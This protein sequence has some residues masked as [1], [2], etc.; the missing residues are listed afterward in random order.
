MQTVAIMHKASA[1]NSFTELADETPKLEDSH[2][3]SA[4]P[5][6]IAAGGEVLSV[7]NAKPDISDMA[8]NVS[9]FMSNAPA[10]VQYKMFRQINQ[11]NNAI[12]EC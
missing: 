1:S 11:K 12:P 9:M 7:A 5:R 8:A 6:A 10:A 3:S 4:I 2:F